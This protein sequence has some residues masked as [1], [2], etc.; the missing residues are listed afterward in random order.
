MADSGHVSNLVSLK[1]ARDIASV[2]GG[3]YQPS[4]ADL[5]LAALAA[6]C[7]SAEGLLDSIQAVKTPYRNATAACEDAFEPLSKLTTRVQKAVK[8]SG[9]PASF[10]DDLDTPARKLKGMRA[11]PVAV[12]DPNTPVDES[13]K[14]VSASQMGRQQRIENLDEMRGLLDSQP[15]YNPNEPDLKVSS[16][17]ALSITLQTLVDNV[18]TTFATFSDSLAARDTGF[19]TDPTNVVNTGRLF[20]AYVESAFTRNSTEWNQVK[21]LI[22]TDF[23]RTK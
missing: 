6:Q 8:A 10:I 11:K 14:S 17:K 1:K 2:W 21:G 12:N 7:T 16:L 4:H 9:C 5:N 22:F 15:L 23:K 3:K 13:A 20:K 19:Y 18:S